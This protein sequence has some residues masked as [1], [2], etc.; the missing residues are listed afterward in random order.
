MSHYLILILLLLGLQNSP[1]SLQSQSP[2]SLLDYSIRIKTYNPYL[3]E[4]A[5]IIATN[6]AREEYNLSPVASHTLLHQ[7]AT[8]YSIEQ[9][10]MQTLSH[11]SIYPER[12]HL[13]DRIKLEGIDLINV[14]IGENLGVDYIL[15]I[16][17]RYYYMDTST[18]TQIP[19][20]AETH[21]PILNFTYRQFG[22]AMVDHWI[23]SPGHR[24]NLL[25]P[26]FEWIGV[27]AVTGSFQ[28]FESIYVTQHFLG[29][30]QPP[31]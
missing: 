4:R 3:L 12:L 9:A 19:V 10:E 27:G 14:T 17:D 6:A 24:E 22:K 11:T 15:Q 28:E 23:V 2:T 29:R 1:D 21:K 13:D 20:D 7:S 18:D 31:N 25:N 26:H 5:I 30:I 16:A 8:T